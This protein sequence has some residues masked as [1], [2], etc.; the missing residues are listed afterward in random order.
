MSAK[1]DSLQEQ[2]H[3]IA[4]RPSSMRTYALTKGFIRFFLFRYFKVRVINREGLNVDG[5]AIYAPVHRS[6]LDSP[7]IAAG[8]D[9][10]FRVLA[11]QSLFKYAPAKWFIASLGAFPVE[12]G[13]ADRQALRTAVELLE[14][15]E[16]MLV[17]PEGTRQEGPEVGEVF[18]GVAYLAAKS[19]AVVVP[20]ALAGT[21]ESMPPGVRFPRRSEVV[22]VV[23]DQVQPPVAPK[24]RLTM[25]GRSE[26]ST[27][28]REVL[29]ELLDQANE[30]RT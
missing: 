18:D 11:K 6:N 16:P 14:R 4:G 26:Y 15:G 8:A 24:G 29:Q 25:S 17:F 20:I 13:A 19:G 3:V 12:R 22:I 30:E 5:A 7:L 21:E 23:G 28:L 10:R 2:V 27:R 9:R 1:T